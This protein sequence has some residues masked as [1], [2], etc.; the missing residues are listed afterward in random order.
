MEY[1]GYDG[2]I[3][4][5]TD[6]NLL[7]YPLQTVTDPEAVRRDLEYYEDKLD[8]AG[9]AMSF[10]IPAIEWARL[11]DRDKTD[12][13]WRK[14]VAGHTHGAF[15]AFSETAGKGDTCFMT[16]YGGVLQAVIN[17][18]CGLELT[19]D[20]VRQVPS[21][22]PKGWKSVTVKGVGPQRLTFKNTS[23]K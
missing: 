6:A 23:K 4:K 19:D 22:M 8:P 11:G 5:Q 12:A 17:G 16:G 2:A 1:E 20:G 18:F 3:I 10:A 7:A 9:P 14:T 21:V 13:L 15:L